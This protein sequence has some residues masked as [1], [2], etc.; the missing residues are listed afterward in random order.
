MTWNGCELAFA[1]LKATTLYSLST[2]SFVAWNHK[3]MLLSGHVLR[4]LLWDWV[5]MRVITILTLLAAGQLKGRLH[6]QL[7][8]R[9]RLLCQECVSWPPEPFCASFRKQEI[10]WSGS[11][12][13]VD[14]DEVPSWAHKTPLKA[15][16]HRSFV[17]EIVQIQ[18]DTLLS[19]QP[20]E[21]ILYT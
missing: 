16:L 12:S 19:K 17:A 21:D 14:R 6:P 8:S 7:M 11:W 15:R 10:V 13:S 3:L 18:T 2:F 5:G 1:P 9:C 4:T 20:D